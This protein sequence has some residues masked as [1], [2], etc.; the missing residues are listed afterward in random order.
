MPI[1]L[2]DPDH[3][4]A[5]N[6]HPDHDPKNEHIMQFFEYAHLDSDRQAVSAPFG[7][8]AHGIVE[9]VPRNPERTAALRK[10]LEAKDCA[11]RAR[12]AK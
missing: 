7:A 1:P 4:N 10:L 2:H 3:L 6:R 8:L 12:F 5:M 11:V 9:N